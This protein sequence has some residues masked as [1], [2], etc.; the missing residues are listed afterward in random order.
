MAQ[1][2][3][4]FNLLFKLLTPHSRYL[5]KQP[6]VY[7]HRR[8]EGGAGVGEF[9]FPSAQN[10]PLTRISSPQ[11]YFCSISLPRSPSGRRR[12]S[13]TSPLSWSR[14]RYPSVIPIS[15][16]GNSDRRSVSPEPP[17][18]AP[19]L[20]QQRLP[21]LPARPPAPPPSA[22]ELNTRGQT[23]LP[24]SAWPPLPSTINTY[25][26]EQ[27]MQFAA[28]TVPLPHAVYRS[29]EMLLQLSPPLPLRTALSPHY[30]VLPKQ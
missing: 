13:R 24:S 25:P 8:W 28:T 20:P 7:T 6:N 4:A 2:G 1:F 15:W 26:K 17:S 27:E 21:Q 18:P 16:W 14:E 19:P 5:G 30:P 23:K 29:E 9:H 22:W 3:L 12:S 11:S 10:W